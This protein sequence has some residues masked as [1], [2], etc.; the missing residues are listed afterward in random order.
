MG[1][2]NDQLKCTYE[3]L[4]MKNKIIFVVVSLA[5]LMMALQMPLSAHCQIP[6]GIYGDETRFKL[7]AEH[8]TTIEKSMKLIDSLGKKS[9][10]NYNQIVRW[11][12]NKESHAAE[13]SQMLNDYFLAQRIK[14]PGKGDKAKYRKYLESLEII[15][16]LIFYDRFYLTV[17][18]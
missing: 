15:H 7:M 9:P 1:S 17:F 18:K 8:I 13:L 3:E 6:C 14:H 5:V 16:Q 10:V 4:K 12:V 11:T 2:G